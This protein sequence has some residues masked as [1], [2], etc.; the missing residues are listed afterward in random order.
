MQPPFPIIGS[1]ITAEIKSPNSLKTSLRLAK[2]LKFNNI[3]SR[4]TVS[5]TPGLSGKPRVATPDPA[6]TNKAS[7]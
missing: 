7:T 2:S 6:C 3:V 5:E 4:V 1:T